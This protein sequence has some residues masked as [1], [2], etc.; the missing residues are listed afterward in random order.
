MEA[1]RFFLTALPWVLVTLLVISY[2]LSWKVYSNYLRNIKKRVV[3][4]IQ[5]D[6]GVLTIGV[7]DQKLETAWLRAAQILFQSFAS[8]WCET[9]TA[10]H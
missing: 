3:N 2:Y 4:I 5:D 1:L 8:F 7:T 6:W 10:V 9:R